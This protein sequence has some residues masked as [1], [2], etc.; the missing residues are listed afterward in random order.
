[1]TCVAMAKLF[2]SMAPQQTSMLF[3]KYGFFFFNLSQN[4]GQRFY[5]L[6]NTIPI[7]YIM[8][9]YFLKVDKVIA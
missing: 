2:F 7:I 8:S 3:D 5:E 4:L 9:E 6:E 1:M